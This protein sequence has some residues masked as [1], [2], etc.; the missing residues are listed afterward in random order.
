VVSNVFAFE[1]S[2]DG[3]TIFYTVVDEHHGRPYQVG[4]IENK[5]KREEMETN[6]RE[7]DSEWD[8][9][10]QE[11]ERKG[12]REREREERR[13][14]EKERGR[15]TEDGAGGEASQRSAVYTD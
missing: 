8:N 5:L 4:D 11:R 10:R 2:S 13:E 9:G 14:R 3:S 6:E 7:W 12:M 15:K 1:W